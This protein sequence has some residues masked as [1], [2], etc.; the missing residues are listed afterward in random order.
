METNPREPAAGRAA[1]LVRGW[2]GPVSS[3]NEI[4]QMA[5]RVAADI[6]NHIDP[7]CR[8]VTPLFAAHSRE[9]YPAVHVFSLNSYLF[10]LFCFRLAD[11]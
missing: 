11:Y 3:D 5:V 4:K 1:V 7:R 9:G 6:A 2:G 10:S 8:H